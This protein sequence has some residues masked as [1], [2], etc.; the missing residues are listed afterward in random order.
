MKICREGRDVRENEDISLGHVIKG[1]LGRCN[2]GRVDCFGPRLL[3]VP[4]DSFL[5]IVS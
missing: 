5:L 3:S 4:V 2:S 1:K